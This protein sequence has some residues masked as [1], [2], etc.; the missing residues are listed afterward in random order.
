MN[1]FVYRSRSWNVG[2]HVTVTIKRTSNSP[3][4]T[5]TNDKG[6]VTNIGSLGVDIHPASKRA[7]VVF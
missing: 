7:L 1:C 6:K 5:I 3:E 2:Q 4:V